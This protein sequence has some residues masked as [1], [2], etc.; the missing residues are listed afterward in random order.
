MSKS[1]PRRHK[2]VPQRTCVLCRKT[3]NKR[4]LMRVVRTP[5][6]GVHIDPTGKHNGRGAYV[7]QDFGCMQEDMQAKSHEKVL[8]RVYASLER[9]LRTTLTSQDQDRIRDAMF[10]EQNL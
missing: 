5:D 7:C 3:T 4:D 1:N 6:A 2:H 9:A 8:H 10:P